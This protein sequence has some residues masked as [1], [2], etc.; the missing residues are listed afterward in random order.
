VLR[1]ARENSRWG[2]QRIV[3]ELAGVG[4][5]ASATTVAKILRQAGL[6]PAGARVWPSWREFVRAH[7]GSIIACDLFTVETCGCV[8]SSAVPEVPVCSEIVV[9]YPTRLSGCFA[10][11]S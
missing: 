11:R 10:K 6:A 9:T 5:R 7:A 4:V 2:C 3:G 1:L 8:K